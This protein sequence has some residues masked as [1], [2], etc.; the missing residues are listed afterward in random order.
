MCKYKNVKKLSLLFV[1]FLMSCMKITVTSSN[2]ADKITRLNREM[3]QVKA[4]LTLKKQL[5]HSIDIG[6][7]SFLY[8]YNFKDFGYYNINVIEGRVLLTGSVYNEEIKKYIIGKITE[9]IK[10]REL[11]DELIVDRD[12]NSSFKDFAIERSIAMKIFFRTKIK[13][14]NYEVSVVNGSAYVIGIAENEEELKLLTH[15]ISTVKGIK[16]VVSY[17]ITVDS[18]KKIKLEFL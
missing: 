2:V 14:L 5:K 8:S 11:M 17:V 9:N 13:S 3:P 16:E 10:V 6:K 1:L 7:K 18:S 12:I 4:D 15:T